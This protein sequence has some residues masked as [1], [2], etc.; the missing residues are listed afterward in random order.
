I[1]VKRVKSMKKFFFGLVLAADELD[2]IDD[3]HVHI[4]IFLF[5]TFDAVVADTP[6]DIAR[7][8]FRRNILRLD[9]TFV[10]CNDLVSNSLN[11]MGLPEPYAAIDE[12]RIIFLPRILGDRGRGGEGK[13]IGRADD[14]R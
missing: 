7:I 11:E 6:N 3:E 1:L 12:E 13:F 14:E 2:I 4:A 8:L 9:L 10:F 5:N